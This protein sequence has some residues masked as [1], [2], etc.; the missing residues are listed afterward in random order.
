MADPLAGAAELS[1]L[2][3]GDV[4][5]VLHQLSLDC[6][7]ASRALDLAEHVGLRDIRQSVLECRAEQIVQCVR[8]LH[9]ARA[10]LVLQQ[11]AQARELAEKSGR[12]C[13]KVL[14][15][16]TRI[17]VIGC[18]AMGYCI[19]SALLRSPLVQTDQASLALATRG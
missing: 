11:N 1:A 13:D 18:G 3:A 7:S 8:L 19:G 16:R 2:R 14:W 4:E 10:E 5:G 12:P 9:H 15:T 6:D 17:G